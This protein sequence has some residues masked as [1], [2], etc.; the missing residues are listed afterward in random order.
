M[1]TASGFTSFGIIRKRMA[2]LYADFALRIKESGSFGTQTTA[3]APDIFPTDPLVQIMA[4]TSASLHEVWEAVELWY[5][6]LDPNT[7]EGVY[8]E[9]L[10][11]RR[12]GVS[13]A[14]G[15]GDPEYRTAILN[16][17]GTKTPRTNIEILAAA[18]PDVD[19]ALLLTSTVENPLPNIPAP[20]NALVVKGADIDFDALAQDIFTHVEL[21]LHQFYGEQTGSV[22]ASPC[23]T[24]KFIK[25]RPLFCSVQIKGRPVD[26]CT[27][28]DIPSLK[29]EAALRLS[30]ITNACILGSNI[31]SADVLRALGDLP[32]MVVQDVKLA[33]RAKLL[34]ACDADNAPLV[35]ID[36]VEQPWAN[37][38]IC[39]FDAG[40]V[41]CAEHS[42]CLPVLP[43]EYVAFDTQFIE[44][45]FLADEEVC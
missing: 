45:I 34:T 38:K 20:G 31:S 16:L 24:Y 1:S 17:L 6:Q 40:E 36:G 8:L 7:A 3:D 28:T 22:S 30:A 27:A 25:A 41:W 39:G 23:V 18:R 44:I 9:Y 37:D 10:H 35:T 15:Q 13:R 19:C 12:L 21:G 2:D 29:A 14:V 32:S 33:R 26:A 11:G 43:W 4:T 5:A 42:G